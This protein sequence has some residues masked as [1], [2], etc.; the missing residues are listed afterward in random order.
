[1][2]APLK[3]LALTAALAAPDVRSGYGVYIPRGL[4]VGL[5][6]FAL[7]DVAGARAAF[8]SARVV[9]EAG[10]RQAPD[11]PRMQQT[12]V[13]KL[14]VEFARGRESNALH[15]H[16]LRE[17]VR[18]VAQATVE[19]VAEQDYDGPA[20]MFAERKQLAEEVAR[21]T[22]ACAADEPDV[23]VNAVRRAMR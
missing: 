1:M 2:S 3:F 23:A 13:L 8:D 19:Y 14:S 21:F 10:V 7:G 16:L 15:D 6:K 17:L 5:A 9:A 18:S 11:D 4:Q 12:E 22:M 20:D